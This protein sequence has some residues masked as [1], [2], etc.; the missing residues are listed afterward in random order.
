MTISTS[1]IQGTLD[2]IIKYL[3]PFSSLIGCHMV[4]YLTHD[5]WKAFVPQEIQDEIQTKEN[6]EEA[7]DMFWNDVGNRENVLK[8]SNFLKF[9]EEGKKCTYD[10]LTN[11]W[12]DGIQIRDIL[13]NAG[14]SV[15]GDDCFKIKEFM[16]KKK[17]HEV[18]GL[19][20]GLLVI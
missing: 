3:N 6:I 1:A 12:V 19:N 11:T 5:H 2:A 10:H 18:S 8:F 4:N 20:I 16:S 14:C 13:S 15:D 17:K 9:L 7:I